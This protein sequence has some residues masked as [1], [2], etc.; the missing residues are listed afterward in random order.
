MPFQCCHSVGWSFQSSYLLSLR[1]NEARFVS[2]TKTI[3]VCRTI[4]GHCITLWCERKL[5]TAKAVHLSWNVFLNWTKM[6][7]GKLENWATMYSVPKYGFFSSNIHPLRRLFLLISASPHI[8][9][10]TQTM[11]IHKNDDVAELLF[12]WM[13]ANHRGISYINFIDDF[14]VTDSCGLRLL[15]I[16]PSIQWSQDE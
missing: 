5:N 6:D 1:R 11:R 2:P 12:T 3:L 14:H 4:Y 9:T 8:R 16:R 13:I 7:S 10:H 15:C